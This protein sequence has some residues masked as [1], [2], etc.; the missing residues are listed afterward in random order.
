MPQ[1]PTREQLAK[2]ID[3]AVLA[4]Q[5]GRAEVLAG[6][7]VT[8]KYAVKCLCVKPC[9]NSLAAQTLAGSGVL[10]GAVVGFP[11]GADVTAIKA[12]QARAAVADGADELDMV[13]NIGALRDGDLD[14]LRLDIRAVVEAAQGRCVKVIFEC[15]LLDRAQKIAACQVAEQ[16]GANFVKT[17]TGFAASGATI[18]DVQLMRQTVGPQMQVKASGG[19]RSLQDALAMIQAGATRLGTSAT[20]GILD[21]CELNDDGE[22]TIVGE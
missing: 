15:A 5:A 9:H 6:C 3:H 12:A 7:D 20:A 16:A 18:Q 13:L 2:M 19:I 22:K 4:P 8:M 10:V 21:N 17:S 11:H 14:F 1:T